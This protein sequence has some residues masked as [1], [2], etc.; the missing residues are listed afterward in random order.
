MQDV[1]I[2]Y[3]AWASAISIIIFN[4]IISTGVIVDHANSS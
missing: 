3:C 1:R 2:I 4:I